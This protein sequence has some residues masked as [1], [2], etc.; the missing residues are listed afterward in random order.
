M[1]QD[2]EMENAIM[3]RTVFSDL[4]FLIPQDLMIVCD[5][6]AFFS[7]V[8]DT[9]Y[10]LLVFGGFYPGCWPIF[11]IASVLASL[12][13]T[14]RTFFL[15]QPSEPVKLSRT[16][17]IRE[18]IL[19]VLNGI[20]SSD[21]HSPM[22]VPGLSDGLFHL[23]MVTGVY[24]CY[25]TVASASWTTSNRVYMAASWPSSSLILAYLHLVRIK[26]GLRNRAPFRLRNNIPLEVLNINIPGTN[27]DPT[28]FDIVQYGVGERGIG[29]PPTIEWT[30]TRRLAYPRR[31]PAMFTNV[32]SQ[33]YNPSPNE[34]DR[35]SAP[36]ER[37]NS[38]ISAGNG[39]SVDDWGI[40]SEGRE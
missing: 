32:V 1:D 9:T 22:P 29:Y 17:F 15:S 35:R 18:L 7:T 33:E 14:C 8:V 37:E 31:S 2:L 36:T 19:I 23:M 20:L 25:Q 5:T 6:I 11:N 39:G 38:S 21:P 26:E 27:N 3:I 4:I 13:L 16:R 30:S 40:E 24:N 28:P 10:L 12:V 34:R